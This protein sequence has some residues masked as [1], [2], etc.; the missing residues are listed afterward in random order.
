MQLMGKEMSPAVL[1]MHSD[2]KYARITD[3]GDPP[4]SV[5]PREIL[6]QVF[7]AGG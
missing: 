6:T 1:P 5:Q 7:P 4:L 3:S 2:D